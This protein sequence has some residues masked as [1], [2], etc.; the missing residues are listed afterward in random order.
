[1]GLDIVEYVMAVE[2]E[3]EI[4]F[5]DDDL[6]RTCS[7]G[8][9]HQL[10]LR[11]IRTKHP[12]VNVDRARRAVCVSSRG[13][14]HLRKAL[15]Q[16]GFGTRKEIAP[17]TVL[18]S[19]IPKENRRV[20]WGEL[21]ESM[22]CELPRLVRSRT[23]CWTLLACSALFALCPIGLGLIQSASAIELWLALSITQARLS[24]NRSQ[25]DEGELDGI[26]ARPETFI[27]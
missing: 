18:E 15:I 3:F 7:V 2:Q 14:Y 1:M 20:R 6:G 16:C 17:K 8:E 11:E 24:R 19:T 27:A 9:F 21:E 10:V 12:P 26:R 25:P 4:V 22:K 13:F 23:L 5:D